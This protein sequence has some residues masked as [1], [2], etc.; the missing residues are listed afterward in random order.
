MAR[1]HICKLTDVPVNSMREFKVAHG[2]KVCVVNSGDR[3]FACQAACPH[4][5]VALCEGAF[6]GEMLTCL[7][8]LWQWNLRDGGAPC[9]LAE[10]GL[11]MYAT[12]VDGDALYLAEE[13]K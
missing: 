9:G 2:P 3:F 4:Q 7:E 10:S 8:H 12:E 6:D 1:K 5:G 11:R 13:Q